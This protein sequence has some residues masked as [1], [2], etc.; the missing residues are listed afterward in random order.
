M[1]RISVPRHQI[2]IFTV[3]NTYT[4]WT[5][6]YCFFVFLSDSIFT[7]RI[8]SQNHLFQSKQNFLPPF[9]ENYFNVP[10]VTV[11]N[12]HLVLVLGVFFPLSTNN[13]LI[14]RC[15]FPEFYHKLNNHPTSLSFQIFLVVFK[16]LLYEYFF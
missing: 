12:W 1:A 10:I 13:H 11:P 7:Y 6:L 16:L 4:I 14:F 8:I 15:V 9:L 2:K 3:S 5:S